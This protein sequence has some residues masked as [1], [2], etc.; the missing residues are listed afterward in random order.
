MSHDKPTAIV[1]ACLSNAAAPSNSI[2]CVGKC[3]IQTSESKE[4]EALI[5]K[6]IERVKA[7]AEEKTPEQKKLCKKL[8]KQSVAECSSWLNSIVDVSVIDLEV[9]VSGKAVLDTDGLIVQCLMDAGAAAVVFSNE[10]NQL[11]DIIN[12]ARVPCERVC[13]HFNNLEECMNNESFQSISSLVTSISV[14]LPNLSEDSLSTFQTFLTDN[15]AITKNLRVVAQVEAYLGDSSTQVNA[16]SK[17]D[18]DV[19]LVDPTP[20]DLGLSFAACIR[21]D[22]P[23]GLY[24]TVVC[25]R[26]GEA[27]GLVYSSK[28]S[29]VAALEC[30]RGVYYSRSRNSLWRKGD[31]S[32]HFQVRF[33][34]EINKCFGYY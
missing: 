24:T 30:G 17:K 12:V 19:L 22:R 26:G 2:A 15:I 3:R 13:A 10:D 33:R 18:I 32:G 5:L 16:F 6:N 25:S 9:C 20:N 7:E 21:T 34:V 28:E 11:L 14:G 27:L 1:Y 4:F 31:S 23:D 8:M 29:I